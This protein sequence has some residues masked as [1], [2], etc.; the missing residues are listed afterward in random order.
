MEGLMPAEDAIAA[1]IEQLADARR[2]IANL[3]RLETS[4][5]T[6]HDPVTLDANSVQVNSLTGQELG[7]QVQLHN[8]AWIGPESGAP[9]VPTF[10]LLV[11]GD[12]PIFTAT[13]S[14]AAPAAPFTVDTD[15]GIYEALANT[16]GFSTGARGLEAHFL[17]IEAATS[18]AWGAL[19][20]VD[21]AAAEGAYWHML[22]VTTSKSV[23]ASAYSL[24][25]FAKTFNEDAVVQTNLHNG[26]N[27]A[28]SLAVPTVFYQAGTNHICFYQEAVANNNGTTEYDMW[29]FG[30]QGAFA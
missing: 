1:I 29:L 20:T 14:A 12:L 10:R 24:D 23:T 5:Y 9:A 4:S 7:L 21:V 30:T 26:T 28:T 6:A 8:F 11:G 15:T 22:V 19:T 17:R 3:E 2:R 16:L 27:A 18:N 13:G 25:L